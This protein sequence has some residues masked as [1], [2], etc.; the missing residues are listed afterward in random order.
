[1]L[2]FV[3]PQYS[4]LLINADKMAES[5]TNELFMEEIR[6]YPVI[7]DRY[8]KDF[9]DQDKKKNA[10]EN[11]SKATGLPL[12]ECQKRYKNIRTNY[13]RNVKKKKPSGSE[14]TASH[15][16]ESHHL[17]WLD[18]FVEHCQT[19]TNFS[20]PSAS[21]S[22][23]S[24]AES[25]EVGKDEQQLFNIEGSDSSDRGVG[26]G[27]TRGAIAPPLFKGVRTY[28]F[29]P[30]TFWHGKR[31]KTFCTNFMSYIVLL[32]V[33]TRDV[34]LYLVLYLDW[35]KVADYSGTRCPVSPPPPNF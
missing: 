15:S 1:M 34:I 13:V 23:A 26:S 31:L 9:K 14:G 4:I 10:W 6:K 35:K 28:V 18:A 29:A 2:V 17:Q 25:S 12:V 20:I 11:V 3:S 24:D 21:T 5:I 19:F 22:A 7:Y 32:K 16:D 33:K 27:G 8:I 30:P